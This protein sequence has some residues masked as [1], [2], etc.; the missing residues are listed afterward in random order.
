MNF[1]KSARVETW[2]CTGTEVSAHYDPMLAKL[3]VTA[4]DRPAAVR[5]LQ[6]ALDDT[7]LSGLATNLEWLRQVVR[8]EFFTSGH[9]ATHALATVNHE[10]STIRVISGGLATT[11]QD[12]PG[13]LGYWAVG[14]PPS[15]PMDS[16]AFRLGNRLL[17]NDSGAA[18]IEITALGPT[19]EFGHAAVICLAGA[20]LDAQLDDT[21]LEPYTPTAVSAGQTL[22]LGRVRGHG[23]RAYLLLQGGLDVP[24]YLGSRS[25]F[26]LG[27]FGGHGGR[28]LAAGDVLRLAHR[29]GVGVE[30]ALEPARRPA[31]TKS[32][33]LRV[34]HG[35]HG[36]PDFFT[37]DDLGM[38]LATDWKVH[39]NSN[40]TGV[41]L[42][43]PKPVWARRDGGELRELLDHR[44]GAVVCFWRH[45]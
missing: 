21:S 7:R 18:G 8:S 29:H 16:L 25:T 40:R 5:A 2:V 27:G 4:P 3:I 24:E 26:T 33:T 35:P 34:L 45:I 11:V 20:T 17:G 19:L 43:G 32:W 12:Y 28:A 36:A 44:L 1:P 42:V 6:A 37:A 14:V 10:P 31:L 23:L 22:R 13:R 39:Y 9:V 41:R 38:V 30:P 15:G